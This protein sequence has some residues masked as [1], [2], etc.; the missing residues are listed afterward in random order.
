MFAALTFSN[1]DG[2][3]TWRQDDEDIHDLQAKSLQPTQ[4]GGK[5]CQSSSQLLAVPA[6]RKNFAVRRDRFGCLPGPSFPAFKQRPLLR[7]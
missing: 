5:C 2:M 6:A 3:S 4:T 1:S 7:L